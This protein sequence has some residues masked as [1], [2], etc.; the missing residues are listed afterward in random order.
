[1]LAGKFY[2]EGWI[3]SIRKFVGL[4]TTK[5]LG[6]RSAL[7]MREFMSEGDEGPTWEDYF[8]VLKDKYPIRYFIFHTL[9]NK[10]HY[11]LYALGM[12]WYHFKCRV[13]PSHQWHKLNL[14]GVDPEMWGYK[15]GY[16]E[17]GQQME[18]AMW[19]CLKR[20]AQDMDNPDEVYADMSEED[21]AAD[22]YY[23]S[24]KELYKEVATLYEWLMF[25]K[26]RLRTKIWEMKDVTARWEAEQRLEAKNMEMLV[27][28]LAIKD[29]MWD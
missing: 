10:L 23:V 28:L 1:M 2:I 25:D 21:R 29:K 14:V 19:A 9:Y 15:G 8:D 4:P 20:F 18:L 27:R 22:T 13:L 7:P 6:W 11:K 12:R 26:K 24:S 5:D 16:L 17:P 3:Y